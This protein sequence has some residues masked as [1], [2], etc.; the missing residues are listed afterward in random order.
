M[1]KE[2]M[3]NIMERFINWLSSMFSD[4]SDQT[5]S[6]RVLAF[7]AFGLF[8]YAVVDDKSAEVLKIIAYFT[9]ALVGGSV[10]EKFTNKYIKK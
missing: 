6:K 1:T 2:K 9:G 4:P 8:V 10:V 3:Q 7:L 5:S